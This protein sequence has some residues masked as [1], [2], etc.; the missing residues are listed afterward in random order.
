MATDA[1]LNWLRSEWTQLSSSLGV[2]PEAS[3]QA[4]DELVEHYFSPGRYYHTLAHIQH[5]LR[6]IHSLKDEA[7]DLPAVL[8]AAWYHD[9]IYDS[10]AKDNEE[11]SAACAVETLRRLAIEEDRIRRVEELI[12]MTKTHEA[13]AD[14]RDAAVLLDADLAILGAAPA[15]YD[16]YGGAIRREYTWV[17]EESYRAGRNAVLKKFIQR[18]RI[19]G[20]DRMNRDCENNGRRNLQREIDSLS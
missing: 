12:L 17:P 8:L 20:T 19:F 1:D 16:E 7:R 15:A 9:V 5:V 13:P 4:F 14:D 2:A 18:R 11:K 6:T 10:K 3:Q